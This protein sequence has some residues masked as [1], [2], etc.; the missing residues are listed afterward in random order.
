MR[1]LLEILAVSAAS[2]AAVFWLVLPAIDY[3]TEMLTHVAQA[4]AP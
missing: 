2:F 3:A 1:P 4:L